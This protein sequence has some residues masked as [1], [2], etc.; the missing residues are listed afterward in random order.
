MKKSAA[1]TGLLLITA[2]LAGL[3]LLVSN[4]LGEQL[5]QQARIR[6]YLSYTPEAAVTLAYDRCT[7]CHGDEK[8]VKYCPRCGPPFIVTVGFMRK[9]VELSNIQGKKIR[10]FSDAELVAITQVWNGLVGNWESD[11][12]RKDIRKL[13]RGDR[14]LL[15]LFETPVEERTIEIVLQDKVAPGSYK[16]ITQKSK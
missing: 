16:E 4:P 3:L 12:P 14:A 13:L 6:G 7:T 15:D 1:M 5:L 9:Y 10:P 2:I 8:I 11:W